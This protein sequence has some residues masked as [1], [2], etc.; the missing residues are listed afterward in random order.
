VPKTP[1][2]LIHP[3]LQVGVP[4]HARG[5]AACYGAANHFNGFNY[6]HSIG[7]PKGRFAW[8]WATV[9]S[10]SRTLMQDESLD[11]LYAEEYEVFV[12]RYGLE[13]QSEKNH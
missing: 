7:E 8:G 4:G 11:T 13:W 10:Q 1:Q 6:P 3:N 2:L 9:R 12:K 5:Y